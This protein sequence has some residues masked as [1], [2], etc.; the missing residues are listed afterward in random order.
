VNYRFPLITPGTNT[1]DADV[2]S[3]L[4]DAQLARLC[5]WSI[6]QDRSVTAILAE[7][8]PMAVQDGSNNTVSLEGILPHCKLHGCLASDGSCHT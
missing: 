6:L 2:Y 8:K 5:Q 3:L 4:T 1:I 7:F